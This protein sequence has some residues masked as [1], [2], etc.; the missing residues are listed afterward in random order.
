LRTDPVSRG[1]AISEESRHCSTTCQFGVAQSKLF[2]NAD[3]KRQTYT[4]T[5]ASDI[6]SECDLEAVSIS[7][8]DF[9][10]SWASAPTSGLARLHRLANSTAILLN[11]RRR[12]KPKRERHVAATEPVAACGPCSYGPSFVCT[13]RNFPIHIQIPDQASCHGAR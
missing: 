9:G 13:F 12:D 4:A 1:L 10:K 6:S 3:R 11:G 2:S 7:G 8:E 5:A